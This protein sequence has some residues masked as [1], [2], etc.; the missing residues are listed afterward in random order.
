MGI[1]YHIS[2]IAETEVFMYRYKKLNNGIR[3]IGEEIPYLKSISMGVWFRAGSATESGYTDGIS[4]FIEHMLFKGTETRNAKELAS[5]IDNLGGVINAFTGRECTCY[6]VK[7]L[8]SHI[9][10]GIDILSDMILNSK[11]DESDIER[12]KSVI[13]EEL[14]MYEDSPED[15]VFD[16]LL[17]KI[18]ENKGVGKNILGNRKS[19]KSI[20]KEKIMEYYESHYVP[21][22]A[23]ISIC[24]NFDFDKITDMLE[25]KFGN[26]SGV[27]APKENETEEF[28]SCCIRKNRDYEQSNLAI[29]FEGV[30]AENRKD[31]YAV[32][33]LNNIVGGGA[34]SRLFQKIREESGLAYS[35][36]SAEE[37]YVHRGEF[38]ICAS[39]SA[40]NLK[41]VYN[42]I[43]EEIR[44]IKE[45][46]ISDEEIKNSK[47]QLKGSYILGN[48]G[49]ES[50]MISMGKSMILKN[51][52][53]TSEEVLEGI[54]SVEP[55][56]I[57]RLV[58]KIF[59]FDRMGICAAGRNAERVKF[60]L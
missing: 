40:E 43:I 33:V 13:L 60:A 11:F 10:V 3:V 32:S 7:L 2:K 56:N 52:A 39:M 15:Y 41:K 22:N 19:I 27:H 42:L 35:I 21:E 1:K 36:Y 28:H 59:D 24:G 12:E 16:T 58:D 34:S 20:N 9:N 5:R 4:H 25:E 26:W 50:R 38:T 45:N 37:V 57:K 30:S 29:C 55:D 23:V 17:E 49:T 46:G 6:Y 14:K 47:E 51:C 31:M 8:D 18:Y 48:E 54:E 44:D 53:E